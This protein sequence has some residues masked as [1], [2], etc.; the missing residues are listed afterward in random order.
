[1]SQKV[2]EQMSKYSLI[3]KDERTI[4]DFLAEKNAPVKYHKINEHLRK[5]KGS[6]FLLSDTEF[7]MTGMRTNG[8]VE[9]VNSGKEGT[10]KITEKGLRVYETLKKSAEQ[11]E[12]IAKTENE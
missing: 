4:F 10:Y 9:L 2:F 7:A 3:G 8:L 11:L 12:E 6:I 5:Q 1:M